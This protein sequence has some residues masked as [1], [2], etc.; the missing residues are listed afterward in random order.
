MKIIFFGTPLF[1]LESMK[2]LIKDKHEILALITAPDTKKGRGRK[3]VANAIKNYAIDNNIPVLQ[4]KNLKDK[5]FIT[6]V[7]SF[8]ADVFV[9]VAFRMLP[10]IIWKI[11]PKGTINL[12]TSLLPNYR[13]AAPI[14][15]VLINGEESTG[16]STFFINEK[17]DSGEIILQKEIKINKEVTAGQ[18]HNIL[19]E[20]GKIILN[21]TIEKI[22]ENS[23]KTKKQSYN[24]TM[25]EAP[26]LSKEL[27]KIDWNKNATQ[28]HNLIR[29]LSPYLNQEKNLKDVSICPSAWFFLEDDRG[30]KRR[31]KLHLTELEKTKEKNHLSIKTDNISFMKIIIKDKSLSILRLHPEGKSPM[32]IKEFLQGNKINDNYKLL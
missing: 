17:I 3:I 32:S 23:Y 11:P 9:V 5:E 31:I 2:S 6:H 1:A 13:G 20:E 15:R 22:K 14:N 25:Q 4:P 10:E 21:H 29:G 18:L 28:I 16:V 8:N 27:L 30:K 7:K 19:L 26:K 24:K 12:H